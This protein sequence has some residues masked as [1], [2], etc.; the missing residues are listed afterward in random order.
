MIY[1]P[2][3]HGGM[4]TQL[5]WGRYEVDCPELCSARFGADRVRDNI[6][7]I[8]KDKVRVQ[9]QSIQDIMML[10]MKELQTI[11]VAGADAA[12]SAAV[13]AAA[14]PAGA[15]ASTSTTNDIVVEPGTSA[16]GWQQL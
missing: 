1:A 12:A 16:I 13:S 5:Q 14:A 6:S 9:T 11:A 3:M 4:S 7:G 8:K 10:L 2:E 15:S